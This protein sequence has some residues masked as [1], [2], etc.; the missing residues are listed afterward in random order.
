MG[1]VKV[2]MGSRG[3]KVGWERLKVRMG[4]RGQTGWI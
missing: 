3:Q 1:Q 4:E 2:R